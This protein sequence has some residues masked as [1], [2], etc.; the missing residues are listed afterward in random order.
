[1][2]C[3]K[4]TETAAYPANDRRLISVSALIIVD[5]QPGCS[6]STATIQRTRVDHR[7]VD[8]SVSQLK[9]EDLFK[10]FQPF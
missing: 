10:T 1:M 2:F 4:P 8:M 6:P 9:W 5:D 7:G 3:Q